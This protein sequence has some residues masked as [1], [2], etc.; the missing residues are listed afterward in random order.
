M[1]G[2]GE[3]KAD[4]GVRKVREK[5]GEWREMK[6]REK[7]RKEVEIRGKGGGMFKDEGKEGNKRRS[8]KRRKA[9]DGEKKQ[10]V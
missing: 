9:K 6:G 7:S 10:S 2:G 8:G 4:V 5:E 3:G 1:R